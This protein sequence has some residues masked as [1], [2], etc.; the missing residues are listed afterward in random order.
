MGEVETLQAGDQSTYPKKG[1]SLVMHYTGTL[2]DGTVFDSSIP[3]G[4]PFRFTIGVGQ[5]IRGWDEGVMKMSL[6][7]K[8]KLSITSDFGYGARGAGGVIPPNA[9]LNF[10]VE[11]LGING[12]MR[13]VNDLNSCSAC[14]KVEE[15]PG[16]LSRCAACKKVLY[17]E[18]NVN[19]LIGVNINH[20]V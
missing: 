5:V 13:K 20:F 7:E 10:E 16:K 2:T 19:L 3:K 11:L 6:G 14:A 1:D 12:I 8:A 18:E 17:W 4:R 15:A 9:D